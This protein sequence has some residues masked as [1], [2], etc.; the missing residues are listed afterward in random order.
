MFSYI[1]YLSLS[2]SSVTQ[3]LDL[4]PRELLLI[5]QINVK[6]FVYNLL[7]SEQGTCGLSMVPISIPSVAWGAVRGT[8]FGGVSAA[9]GG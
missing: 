4:F 2:L 8:D 5:G 9:D 7:D 1:C 3:A 6:E